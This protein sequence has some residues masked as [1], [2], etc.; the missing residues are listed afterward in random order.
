MTRLDGGVSRRAFLG[1]TLGGI[2]AGALAGFAGAAAAQDSSPADTGATDPSLRYDF[3]GQPHPAGIATPPQRHCLFMTF[4]L[5]TTDA[6]QLQSLLARWSAAFDVLMSG[7]E[8]GDAA[9]DRPHAVPT[10]TGEA[11][12]LGPSGL[13][14][15]LG[16][17]PGV[18]DDRFGLARF[19]PAR[20]EQLP[21][22][23]S[24][25]LDPALTGGDL[26]IQ[27]CADDPQVA[28]HAVRD[29]SRLARGIAVTRWT[30]M[31]FG[32]ASAGK[33]QTTPRNLMGFKD[34]TRNIRSDADLDEFVWHD[35]ADQAWM[36]GGSYQVARKIHM[37]IENWDTD[38]IGDQ[39][40]VFGRAKR[41]GAP[42]TGTAELDT[43]DFAAKDASGTP[44]IDPKS[45]VA[46]AS[47][48]NNG[49]LKILR[50]SYN[51]TDGMDETGQIDAGLLFLAYMKDPDQF[52]RLQTRLG[53]SDALN[54]Y[55]SHVGSGVFAVPPTPARGHYVGE[56]LFA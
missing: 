22:L 54:E 2:A 39:E 25:Q 20:F 47:H 12:D 51:F 45:H 1:G 56:A 4:D 53:S 32:R 6:R 7:H 16:L 31:G 19:K 29:L 13:T 50:R 17:G 40:R 3:Y 11:T 24:D 14:L 10:D 43:P 55:I 33:G 5:T 18:F 52:V 41:S 44:V 8:L 38:H 49:G 23:P 15:T 35:G 27:A 36:R 34:G 46:L 30:V 26:S 37:H 9:P 48:E 42:L 21:A 28:F